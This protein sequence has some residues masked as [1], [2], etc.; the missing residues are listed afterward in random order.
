MTPD[1]ELL[2]F[3]A[4]WLPFGRAPAEDVFVTFG[5]TYEHFR[6]RLAD[7]LQ[8]ERRRVAPKTAVALVN[9]YHR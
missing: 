1:T 9:T 7:A 5:L 3:A 4:K 8:H 6:A 2:A